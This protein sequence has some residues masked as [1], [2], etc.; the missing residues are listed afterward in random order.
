VNE[1]GWAAWMDGQRRDG[2]RSLVGPR[3]CGEGRPNLCVAPGKVGEEEKRSPAG[4]LRGI[5]AVGCAGEWPCKETDHDGMGGGQWTPPWPLSSQQRHWGEKEKKDMRI[6]QKNIN[7]NAQCGNSIW[8]CARRKG[9]AKGEGH[10]GKRR[11]T[12]IMMELKCY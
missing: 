11:R 1:L 2:Q 6:T 12:K 3:I 4:Q 5:K 7:S 10:R 9:S 8:E